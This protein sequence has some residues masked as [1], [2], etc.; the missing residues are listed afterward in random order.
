MSEAQSVAMRLRFGCGCFFILTLVFGIND[1]WSVAAG[2]QGESIPPPAGRA[3]ATYRGGLVTPPLPKPQFTLSDTSGA[4]FDF[5]SQTRGYVTLLFFGYTRCPDQCPLHM[6]NIAV[7]LKK[8][9]TKDLSDQVK[10]VFVTTDPARDSPN[11]LRAWLDRFDERFIGLTGSEAAIEAAQ[12]AVGVPPARKTG[13][14][15]GDYAVAHASFVVA[16]TKD[17]L[18]HLIYPSG[19]TQKDWTHDLPRL[20]NEVWSSR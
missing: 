15:A 13:L 16:Y 14:A 8:I 6:A 12:K 11:A 17:N 10:V 3:A 20:V 18:G 19:V 1:D 5:W 9:P 2:P 4:P 7:G